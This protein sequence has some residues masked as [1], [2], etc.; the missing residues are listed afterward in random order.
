MC[1][2]PNMLST[3]RRDYCPDCHYEFYYGDAHA[4]GAAQISQQINAGDPPECVDGIA[5]DFAG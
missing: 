3:A 4:T 1:N 2:H 5:D